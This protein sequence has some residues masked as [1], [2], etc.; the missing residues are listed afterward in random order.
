MNILNNPKKGHKVKWFD[1]RLNRPNET[2]DVLVVD[3]Y[4][5]VRVE[6]YRINK[7]GEQEGFISKNDPV[8][9]QQR[10]VIDDK[11]LYW[12]YLKFEIPEVLKEHSICGSE[13]N[14]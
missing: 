3:K 14:L 11:V 1:P 2:C 5:T 10:D 12:T 13:A 9:W 7:Y 6:M 4:H 8:Q